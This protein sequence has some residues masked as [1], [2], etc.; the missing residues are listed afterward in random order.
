MI[1]YVWNHIPVIGNPGGT[2]LSRT[3]ILE[4]T[5]RK[6]DLTV[7]RAFGTKCYY[8]LTLQKKGGLKMALH[9]KG[10][11]GIILGIEGNMPAYRVM[12]AET[13]T[14]RRIPFAQAVSHEGHYPLSDRSTWT[15]EEHELP[16]SY[17]DAD[18]VGI[19]PIRLFRRPEPTAPAPAASGMPKPSPPPIAAAPT[20]PV[21]APT[22][23]S[24]PASTS[25]PATIAPLASSVPMT[26][27]TRVSLR[28]MDRPVYYPPAQRY[29]TR[30]N[31]AEEYE[32]DEVDE[33]TPSSVPSNL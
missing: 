2:T 25:V 12:D 6:Y 10:R 19:M 1:E 26:E 20:A 17:V 9:E 7:L 11:L 8:L 24:T 13:R 5:T 30:A 28:N 4:G 23:T 15:A 22:A 18:E 32:G 27:S 14:V 21:S 3:A 33:V 29:R 31:M 16:E